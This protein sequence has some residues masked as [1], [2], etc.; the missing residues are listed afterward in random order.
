[1]EITGIILLFVAIIALLI[2]AYRLRR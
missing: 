2:A 1:M